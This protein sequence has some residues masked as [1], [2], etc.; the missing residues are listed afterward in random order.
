MIKTGGYKFIL[1]ELSTKI[2]VNNQDVVDKWNPAN[3]TTIFGFKHHQISQTTS[4]FRLPH[5]ISQPQHHNT[6]QLWIIEELRTQS[7]CSHIN[8]ADN[9]HEKVWWYLQ[10]HQDMFQKEEEL[11]DPTNQTKTLGG[12]F[13]NRFVNNSNLLRL[14]TSTVQTETKIAVGSKGSAK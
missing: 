14:S 12:F 5:V 8:I 9:H 2:I 1:S 6:P 4:A 3:W 11:W 13:I 10:K 7:R